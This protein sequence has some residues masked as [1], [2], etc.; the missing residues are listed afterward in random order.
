MAR[1]GSAD[2]HQPPRAAPS[3]NEASSAGAGL[4]R[5]EVSVLGIGM[6]WLAR[7]LPASRH[8]REE[9]RR[10]KPDRFEKA[11]L[12]MIVAAV[13]YQLFVEPIV[14]VA[15][16]RDSSRLIDPAGLDY[17]SVAAYR[18]SV[19][20]FVETKYAFVKASSNRYLTCAR[21][22]LGLAKVL[23]RV[24][25][26][27]GKF[28]IRCLGFC[29]LVLYTG[30]LLI[31]L[32]A[33]RGAGRLR[34]ILVA[35]AVLV[36]CT[37]VRLV[38]YFN[39][40]YCESAS[41]VFFL[42]TV[43]MALLGIQGPREGR[44]AWL[45]WFGY[46]A[47][48]FL[49]WMTKSQN[50]AFAPSL[51]LG[52]YFLFPQSQFRQQRWLRPL[53]ALIIPVGI[54]WAFTV[55]A[56]GSTTRAN[57][58]TVL[59]EEI[60][61]HSQQPNVD[62]KE[63]LQEPGGTVTL[64]GIARFY[65]KH[66][67]RWWQMSERGAKQAFDY[68]PLGNFTRSSGLGDARSQAFDFWSEF[69]KAHYP[70]SLGLFVGL[71]LGYWIL[72][73]IKARRLDE[74]PVDRRWTLVGPIIALGCAFE[75]VATVTFEANGTARHLFLFNVAVDMCILLAL[76]SVG[77]TATQLWRRYRP[78]AAAPDVAPPRS[79]KIDADFLANR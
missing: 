35:G 74:E 8:L 47:S 61:P 51:T 23:N 26:K 5:G 70:R 4:E 17:E 65:V 29:H 62:R 78:V 58:A 50:T 40:F 12:L 36:L 32:R 69:K 25:S 71:F 24:V 42:S 39:S 1:N 33:F 73:G 41:L 66:P 60:L 57:A 2:D 37:D 7:V 68:L 13:A 79:A 75:F 54:A 31:F 15:D 77:D 20:H 44:P 56:Y 28:D 9:V 27:D 64:A 10:W 19:F 3:S 22:I 53:G 59:E 48:A 46:M 76:L 6:T 21:P 72:A 14:G 30:A 11:V 38:S 63:L 18:K 52:A 16:N 34:R 67:Y 49:F 55:N 43:G 45:L